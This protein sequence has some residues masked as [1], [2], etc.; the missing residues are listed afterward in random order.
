MQ[1]VLLERVDNLGTIGDVVNVKP[2]FARNF[3]LPNDK[4]LRATAANLAR[5]EAEREVLEARNAEMAAKATESGGHLDGESFVMIR[6]AGET[7][8]LY[9]S[10]SA[11]DV[12]EKIGGAVTRSMVVL[13]QPIKALG[14]HDV[15][16]KLHPEVT[17]TVTINVAR[18]EE[19]AVRQAAGEDVIQTQLDEDREQAEEANSE[20]ADIAREM[21]EGDFGDEAISEAADET[22][23]DESE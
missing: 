1:V 15:K 21:F 12:A 11:R 22:A 7:G 14:T 5:F 3:L 18:T 6:K 8:M 2:G 13:E 20:R 4:A 9:G 17:V 10:V 19:E 23:G 16:I